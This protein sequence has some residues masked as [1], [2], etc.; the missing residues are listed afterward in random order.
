M[1]LGVTWRHNH[2][3]LCWPPLPGSFSG[4]VWPSTSCKFLTA[5]HPSASTSSPHGWSGEWGGAV[6]MAGG[7]PFLAWGGPELVPSTPPSFALT[8]VWGWGG[9]ESRVL[10][11]GHWVFIGSNHIKTKPGLNWAALSWFPM[12]H[13]EA[14]GYSFLPCQWVGISVYFP[15][16]V[17]LSEFTE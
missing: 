16:L 10:D 7:M 2:S 3:V 17:Q 1:W 4:N 11:P 6:A 9:S 5:C 14:K 8:V 15:F 12:I 13:S